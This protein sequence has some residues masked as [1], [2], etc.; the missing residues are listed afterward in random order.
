MPIVT[1]GLTH[2][3]NAKDGIQTGNTLQNIAPGGADRRATITGA[4]IQANGLFFD[5]VDDFITIVTNGAFTTVG[6]SWTFEMF[7]SPAVQGSQYELGQGSGYF[8]SYQVDGGYSDI[9]QQVYAGNWDQEVEMQVVDTAL[10]LRTPGQF[11][12]YSLRYNATTKVLEARMN[13]VLRASATM[14]S[15]VTLAWGIGDLHLFR[16]VYNNPYSCHFH[17][18]RMYNRALTNAELT[19]NYGMAKE[20]GLTAPRVKIAEHR[21]HNGDNIPIY[22]IAGHESQP[23]RVKIPEGVGFIGIVP[24]N[25]PNA[26]RIRLRIGGVTKAL[27]K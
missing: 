26:S 4:V 20:I 9:Y 27:E 21:A 7:F 14:A 5:G 22:A 3:W 1:S 15:D 13:N 24:T 2:Y 19:Q 23:L 11:F 8:D 17:G 6:G 10:G 18:M 12:H 16:G 25:D